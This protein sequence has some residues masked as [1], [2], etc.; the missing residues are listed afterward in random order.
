MLLLKFIFTFL[1]I[2]KWEG[3]YLLTE[4]GGKREGGGECATLL[5]VETL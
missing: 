3:I 5:N 4:E 1:S 2:S